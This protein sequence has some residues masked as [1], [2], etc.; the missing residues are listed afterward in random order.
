MD[1][2]VWPTPSHLISSPSP[3][4]SLIPPLLSLLLTWGHSNFEFVRF[5]QR[6]LDEENEM[7]K[8]W[9]E[10]SVRRQTD[11]H[12]DRPLLY[13]TWSGASWR[14]ASQTDWFIPLHCKI[15]QINLRPH[16]QMI[17]V[18]NIPATHLFKLISSLTSFNDLDEERQWKGEN[19]NDGMLG[20]YWSLNISVNC[21]PYILHLPF[22]KVFS[23]L[24]IIIMEWVCRRW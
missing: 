3:S 20:R 22:Q 12:T 19:E 21:Q 11:R 7:T 15:S 2:V 16:L 1:S 24:K 14:V 10:C 18:L 6:L 17:S 5:V 9:T 13:S 8:I 23:L 4:T